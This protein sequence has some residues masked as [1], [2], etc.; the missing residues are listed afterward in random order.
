MRKKIGILGGMGPE[1]LSDMYL[2][3]CK[4]Y[5]ANYGAKYDRDFP[6]MI[7]YSVPIPDVVESIENEEE[8]L[9]MLVEAANILQDDGCDYIAI[10]CNSVQFLLD[11]IRGPLMIKVLGIAEVNAKYIKGKGYKRVGILSTQTTIEKKVYDQELADSGIELIKPTQSDQKIVTE[12]I[13]TQ[14]SG[15]VVDED[16]KK[17]VNVIENFK[18]QGVDAVLI[19]CTDLPLVI[20]QS[21]TDV[22]LV[23]CTE[24]YANETARLSI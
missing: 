22:P 2:G 1:A 24:I 17:L 15:K 20:S 16:T 7:L 8:T 11:R 3:I 13:M 14:L 23:N 9:R 5:Q 18:T 6:P 12:V 4:Y 10:A 19:A 21:D